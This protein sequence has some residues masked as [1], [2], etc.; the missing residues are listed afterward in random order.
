MALSAFQERSGDISAKTYD[1]IWNASINFKYL[2]GKP[3]NAEIAVNQTDTIPR[4]VR[5]FARGYK[6]NAVEPIQAHVMMDAS[7]FKLKCYGIE[8]FMHEPIK[9][10]IPWLEAI[11]MSRMSLYWE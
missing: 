5:A 9:C 10:L 11:P 4:F 7:S 3:A 6:Y 2:F 8:E 1:A